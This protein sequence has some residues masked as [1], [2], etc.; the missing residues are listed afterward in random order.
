MEKSVSAINV[1]VSNNISEDL[2][3]S[4]LSKLPLKSLKWFGCVQKSWAL[5]F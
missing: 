1:K 5:L 3:F 2:A 4:I